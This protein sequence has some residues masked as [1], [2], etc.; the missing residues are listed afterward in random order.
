M[1]KMILKKTKN[2]AVA[3]LLVIAMIFML[4]PQTAFASEAVQAENRTFYFETDSMPDSEELLAGYLDKQFKE[5][6]YEG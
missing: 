2:S 5:A 1:Q 3:I 6:F 4:V